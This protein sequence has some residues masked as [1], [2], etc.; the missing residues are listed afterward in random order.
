[1]D[2][3]ATTDNILAKQK[4]IE[5]PLKFAVDNRRWPAMRIIKDKMLTKLKDNEIRTLSG[6]F[7]VNKETLDKM[8]DEISCLLPNAIRI[9]AGL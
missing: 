4:A 5:I 8:E 7:K 2:A 6:F 9:A 1:M 3:Y